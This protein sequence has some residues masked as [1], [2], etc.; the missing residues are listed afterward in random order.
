MCFGQAM[1]PLRLTVSAIA[2]AGSSVKTVNRFCTNYREAEKQGIHIEH[3]R[4]QLQK[5][6]EQLTNLPLELNENV[7]LTQSLEDLEAAIPDD[8]K[9]SRRRD[10]LLWAAGR[11]SSVRGEI[12][13]LKETENSTTF[14]LV[15]TALAEM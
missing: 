1:D 8:L 9:T 5:N 7:V 15:L 3:Q 11:K 14:A 12:A 2:L 4:L 10:R 6:R 13:R